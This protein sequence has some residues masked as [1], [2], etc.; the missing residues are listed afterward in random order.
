MARL[1]ASGILDAALDLI[2]REGLDALTMRALADRLDVTATALYYHYAGRDELLAAVVQRT[3]E[4]LVANAPTDGDWRAQIVA[5]LTSVVD[6]L[7]TYPDLGIWIITTQS[8][9]PPVMEL[10]ERIIQILVDSGHTNAEAIY[11]KGATL[12]LLIGHLVL[13]AAPESPTKGRIPV[14]YEYLRTT[15][16][17]HLA[18]DRA[19]LFRAALAALLADAPPQT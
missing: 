12:R 19:E 3:T 7:G 1:T 13:S 8:R 6:E 11:V 14:R 16:T 15:H 18:I 4:S 9:Q 2:E 17:E 5:L 10:H